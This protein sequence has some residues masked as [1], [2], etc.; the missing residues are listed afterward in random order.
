M[1]AA[2]VL[3]NAILMVLNLLPILPLDGGRV[4]SSLLP[5]RFAAG[6]ARLEP[7]GLVLIV[8]LLVTGVLWQAI[9][10]LIELTVDALPASRI[11]RELFLV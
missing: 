9:L 5:P 3:V 11:V 1:G 2:G 8:A 6:Y 7:V 10:P 4:L